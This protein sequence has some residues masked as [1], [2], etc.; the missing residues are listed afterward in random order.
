MGDAL[1]T[2]QSVNPPRGQLE[3]AASGRV[4]SAS[5]SKRRVLVAD[6]NATIRAALRYFIENYTNMQVCEAGDGA[7]AVEQAETQEPDVVIM[8][9][10]MPNMNGVE[11]ASVIKSLLPRTRI[12]VFTLHS[13]VIGEALAKAIGVD[14]VVAKSEGAAGLIKVLQPIW[15]ENPPS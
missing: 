14:V 2:C 7:Q 3:A 10:V 5:G 6:D 9:L 11:A 13:D 8:D 12:V 4:I 15:T 1:L